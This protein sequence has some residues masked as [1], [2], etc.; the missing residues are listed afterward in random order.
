[1]VNLLII[2]VNIA[3]NSPQ[4][5]RFRELI[6]QWRAKVNIT[7]ITMNN[8]RD[9]DLDLDLE[10][11][12]VKTEYSPLGRLFISKNNIATKHYIT[13][14]KSIKQRVRE[15]IR[16]I[17]RASI[18]YRLMFPDKF[19]FEHRRILLE[20]RK[21]RNE[22]QAFDAIIV[23]A[24]PFSM[25]RF[26]HKLRKFFPG[27]KL[28]YDAGDPFYGNTGLTLVK[29]LSTTFARLFELKHLPFFDH[30]VVPTLV[31]KE[32]YLKH[33]GEVL[34]EDT[35]H[36]IDQ[37]CRPI[38]CSLQ[39]KI[40]GSNDILRLLYAGG[41]YKELREP[42]E[43][44]KAV[45]AHNKA[46][47][48]I[49]G[50]IHQDL[51]PEESESFFYGG[52]ITPSELLNEYENCDITVFIDNKSGVQVPGKVLELIGIQRPILFIYYKV[53]SPTMNYLE[54]YNAIVKCRNKVDDI[55]AAIDEIAA[56]YPTFDYENKLQNFTWPA[57]A[58][59]YLDIIK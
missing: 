5:I 2:N 26:G 19:I 45:R 4:P 20:A 17:W 34:R 38:F 30:I 13:S 58:E 59:K 3:G 44:Y 36:V 21:L 39:P 14:K 16:M 28:I 46:S 57:L 29:P 25:Q 40:C 48:R 7:L 54:S 24:A 51:L 50:N 32:H 12:V 37:G 6:K 47:L 33:Y 35:V 49:F 10:I 11:N 27:A 55:L 56:R 42:F 15:L 53:D 9:S 43:L 1:M 18:F 31:L 41:L 52:S 8:Y 23:S 22:G